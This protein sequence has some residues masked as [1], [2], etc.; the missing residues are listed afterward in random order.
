MNLNNSICRLC[1]K[2]QLHL[3]LSV[4]TKLERILP[5]CFNNCHGRL[6]PT[7][8]RLGYATGHE[9]GSLNAFKIVE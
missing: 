9:T 4:T 5:R 3:E 7:A 2:S 1:Y 6:V 8:P